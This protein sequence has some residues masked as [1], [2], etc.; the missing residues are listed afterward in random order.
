MTS[1]DGIDKEEYQPNSIP[2]AQVQISFTDSVVSLLFLSQK[3][4][5]GMLGKL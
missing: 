4:F 1:F 2:N 3:Q 5:E